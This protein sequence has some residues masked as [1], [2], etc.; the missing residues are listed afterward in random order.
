L[1]ILEARILEQEKETGRR[2]ENLEKIRKRLKEFEEES[3]PVLRYFEMQNKALKI[4]SVPLPDEVYQSVVRNFNFLRP[5]LPF[6]SLKIV[7]VLGGPGSG[8]GTQCA[9]IS[10]KFRLAH[11]STGDILREEVKNKT[12]VGKKAEELIREGKMIP[13]VEKV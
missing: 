4:S 2:D 8:K 7:F 6:D 12:M 9:E 1:R 13:D 5:T 3:L 10:K 11:I